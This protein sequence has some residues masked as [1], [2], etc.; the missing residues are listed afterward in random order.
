MAVG[1]FL[2]E[3]VVFCFFGGVYNRLGLWKTETKLIADL[4]RGGHTVKPTLSAQKEDQKIGFQ[5]R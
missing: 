4:K 5:D 3:G 1:T 2:F